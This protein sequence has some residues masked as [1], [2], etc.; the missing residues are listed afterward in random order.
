MTVLVQSSSIFTSAMTPL[1]GIGVISLERM[2]PL[3]LGSNIG[4]TATGILASFASS[5]DKLHDTLQIALCHFLFNVS[6]ILIFYPI[7]CTRLPIKLAKK[8]GNTTANYRWFAVFYLVMMFF[9]L[10]AFVFALSLAGFVAFIVIGSIILIVAFAV[11]LINI[12]QSRKPSMLPE[13]LRS[14]S[15][16][17]KWM[18]S[19]QPLDDKFRTLRL[20]AQKTCI[21]CKRSMTSGTTNNDSFYRNGKT[22]SQIPIATREYSNNSTIPVKNGGIE[23][24]SFEQHTYL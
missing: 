10:P 17:P 7:P 16:L 9:I 22:A 3:T 2:Y 14:W 4:T 11:I 15:W 8:L 6:G 20:I 18:H 21:C 13:C 5:Q 19:L 23:N 12:L 1:V 24:L